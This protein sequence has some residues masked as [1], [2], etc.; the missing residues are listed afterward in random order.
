MTEIAFISKPLSVLI[1]QHVALYLKGSICMNIG[2]IES[3]SMASVVPQ[4]KLKEHFCLLMIAHKLELP[5]K[6]FDLKIKIY[7]P[8]VIIFPRCVVLC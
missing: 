8:V 6:L 7:N 3:F 1:V 4:L 2:E 5:E